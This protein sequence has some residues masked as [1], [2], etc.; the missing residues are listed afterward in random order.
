[1]SIRIGDPTREKWQPFL[2]KCLAM[3]FLTPEEHLDKT[4][5]LLEGKTNTEIEKAYKDLNW[6][7][8]SDAWNK[9]REKGLAR[10]MEI[11]PDFPGRGIAVP[12][13]LIAIAGWVLA[14]CLLI[15]II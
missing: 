14:F 12:W 11:L 6:E 15:Y 1:M 7:P 8:W 9:A 5:I 3:G 4:Q 2:D 10:K 13:H